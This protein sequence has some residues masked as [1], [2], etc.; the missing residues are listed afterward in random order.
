[1]TKYATTHLELPWI[2]SA[3]STAYAQITTDA[4][5]NVFPEQ[6]YTSTFVNARITWKY[7]VGCNAE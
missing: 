4:G 3:N 7:K 6:A 5:P 1:M 2:I